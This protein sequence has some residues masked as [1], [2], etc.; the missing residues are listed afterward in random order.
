MNQY[1]INPTPAPWSHSYMYKDKPFPFFICR[2]S[3]LEASDAAITNEMSK[4]SLAKRFWKRLASYPVTLQECV[5]NLT[6]QQY[7]DV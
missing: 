4:V 6:V 1:S 3:Q 2:S 5:L 7:H